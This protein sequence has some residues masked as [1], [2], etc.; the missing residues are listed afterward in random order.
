MAKKS[1]DDSQHFGWVL[2][3]DGQPVPVG[4]VE[5]TK[6]R[7]TCPICGSRMM[8]LISCEISCGSACER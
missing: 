8:V 6:S 5:D 4:L 2:N 1:S 3:D 7:Y